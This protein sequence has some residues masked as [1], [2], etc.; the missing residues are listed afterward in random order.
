MIEAVGGHVYPGLQFLPPHVFNVCIKGPNQDDIVDI[1]S[2]N[3]KKSL[4]I[5]PKAQKQKCLYKISGQALSWF[6]REFFRNMPIR[7]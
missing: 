1:Q 6:L 3:A 2:P 7:T 4:H 5:M